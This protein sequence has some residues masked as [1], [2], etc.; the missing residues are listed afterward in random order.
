PLATELIEVAVRALAAGIA[1][2]VNLLDVQA[3]LVGGGL[4]DKLGEGFVRRVETAMA[5]H[6]FVRPS[7][8]KVVTSSLGDLAGAS[9]G[10][11]GRPPRRATARTAPPPG[12][13]RSWRAPGRRGRSRAAPPPCRRAGGPPGS[14]RHSMRRRGRRRARR[15]RA[16]RG[17]RRRR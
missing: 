11:P 9:R 17:R 6:L 3:V 14:S 1:S 7:P 16:S 12:R 4:G 2:A 15:G 10:P 13:R 8:L 5:P